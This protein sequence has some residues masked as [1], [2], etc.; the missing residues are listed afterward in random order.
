MR[1]G[2]EAA[3]VLPVEGQTGLGHF[4]EKHGLRG[5]TS[6]VIARSPCADDHVGLG[7]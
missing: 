1:S 6:Q 2:V 3:L 7:L 4:H 5:M